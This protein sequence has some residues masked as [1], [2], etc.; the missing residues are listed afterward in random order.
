MNAPMSKLNGLLLSVSFLALL[1]PVQSKAVSIDWS[2]T[3]RFEAVTL[4]STSLSDPKETKSYLLQ[5]LTLSPKIIAVDGVNIIGTFQFL[6]N[7]DYPGSQTGQYFGQRPSLN[8]SSSASLGRNQGSASFDVRHLYLNINQEYG[9]IVV[10]RA[11]VQ[12]GLGMTY[13]AGNGAFDHWGD[14]HDLVG[15][16]F[17][18][19]NLSM[20]PM[21]GKPYDF[22]VAQGRDITDTMIDIQYNNPETESI[23]GVFHTQRN[24]GVSANDASNLLGGT[25]TGDYNVKSTNLILGRGWESFK[26]K[27][28]AGFEQGNTGL[29]IGADDVKVNGYGIVTEMEFPRPQSK[30][31]WKLR[32]G[33]V[34]GDNPGTTNFE[35]YSLHR[36]YDIA[37]MMFNHPLGRYDLFRTGYQ[38]QRSP[39]CTTAPC[40]TY[41]NEESLDEEAISNTI[42]L[43][44][45]FTYAFS[46][47]WA[48]RNSLV[49]AQLQTNPST[50]A[51]NDVSK[52]IGF[53]WDSALVYRPHERILW[54]NEVGLLAPGAA[55]KEGS[56]SRDNNFTF[57]FQSKASISF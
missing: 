26:F 39:T 54:I 13:N 31:D 53:E 29:T 27:L 6:G 45:T 36:N 1:T 25:V 55:F 3:Y 35:G 34:S 4:N 38:R 23:F 40:G 48:W 56:V 33:I 11:P 57:G 30:W 49:Y 28:E 42:F 14:S 44:P 15:Y 22:S 8:A 19:G 16:K 24:A 43:S 20:M 37:F 17:L 47:K 18:V 52:D 50:L 10:G 41:A 21:I 5:N 51:G 46:E 32:A 12:F 2:G 7:P 9:A